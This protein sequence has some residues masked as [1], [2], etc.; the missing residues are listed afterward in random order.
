M[1]SKQNKALRVVL[2]AVFFAGTLCAQ[3]KDAGSLLTKEPTTAEEAKKQEELKQAQLKTETERKIDEAY[4]ALV[5]ACSPE[6]QAWEKTLQENLGNSFYLPRYKAGRVKGVRQSW[7]YVKDKPGLPRVLLIGDSISDCYTIPV[8]DEL[9]GIANVHRAPENCGPTGN[10]LKKLTLWL[11]DE[12]WDV[13]TFNFGIHDR[14]APTADYEARLTQIAERLRTTGAVVLFVNTTP[15]PGDTPKYGSPELIVQKNESARK[16][17]A[18]V[19]IPVVDVYSVVLPK[20]AELQNPKD[21]HFKGEGSRFI[22]KIVADAIKSALP[23]K[24]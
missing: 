4:Q 7:D 19:G 10:G 16:V 22:G 3:T 6:Q 12:K 18:A 15:I 9:A 13:I 21:V 8:Q 11:R 20:L 2:A 1:N 17:M 5:A 24:K 23:K 14:N